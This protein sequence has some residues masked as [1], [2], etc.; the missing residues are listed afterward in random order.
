MSRH[1]AVMNASTAVAHSWTTSTA[2]HYSRTTSTAAPSATV[3]TAVA[4]TVTTVTHQHHFVISAG[5]AS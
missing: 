4:A 1:C 2:A 3:T 5:S